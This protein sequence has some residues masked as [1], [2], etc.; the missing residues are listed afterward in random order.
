MHTRLE[1]QMLASRR[2]IP[3]KADTDAVNANDAF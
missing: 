3:M 1:Y 2:L